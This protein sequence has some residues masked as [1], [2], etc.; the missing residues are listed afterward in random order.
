MVINMMKRV[1]SFFQHRDPDLEIFTQAFAMLVSNFIGLL[2]WLVLRL[3]CSMLIVLTPGII[4]AIVFKET[5]YKGIIKISLVTSTIIS[6]FYVGVIMLHNHA[7][8]QII[9]VA[10]IIYCI[11]ASYKTRYLAS[12]ALLPCSLA[13]HMPLGAI[14][15]IN[16]TIESYLSAILAIATIILIKE[17]M[18]QYKIKK[19][20]LLLVFETSNL[21]KLKLSGRISNNDITSSL[22][23]RIKKLTLKSVYLIK[24]YRYL[25]KS[26]Q[27][28][29]QH[30]SILLDAIIK[31]SRAV[32]MLNN[33]RIFSK[34]KKDC[35]DVPGLQRIGKNLDNIYISIVS[36]KSIK[37]HQVHVCNS[38]QRT[39]SFNNY[40]SLKNLM[41]DMEN[42][43]NYQL[44]K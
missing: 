12:F 3:P 39:L 33:V 40:F 6:I 24:R 43:N 32:T 23:I 20:L 25:Q 13:F 26:N 4:V 15:A 8:F 19:V 5:Q 10:L 29:A 34:D 35:S 42:I 41:R 2:F 30:S 31:I 36:N 7:V 38:L 22:E 27:N 11:F 44:Q 28:F 21:Y 37:I 16:R 17:C 18:A 1:F 14:S 9:W